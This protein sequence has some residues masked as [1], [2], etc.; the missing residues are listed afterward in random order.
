MDSVVG[1]NQ[2]IDPGL[3][4]YDAHG[5]WVG[6]VAL[7]NTPGPSLVVQKGRWLPKNVHLPARVIDRVDE[8]GVY[9]RLSKQDV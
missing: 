7:A 6:I 4:V 2:Q 8:E 5:V 3:S 9:L 1:K